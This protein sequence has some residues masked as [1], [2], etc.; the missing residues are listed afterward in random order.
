MKLPKDDFIE[1]LANLTP[2]ETNNL[3]KEKGK[4]R[5]QYSPFIFFDDYKKPQEQKNKNNV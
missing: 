4:E 5:K 3:I 1:F 2:E